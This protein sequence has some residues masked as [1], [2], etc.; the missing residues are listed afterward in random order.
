MWRSTPQFPLSGVSSSPGSS[1]ALS[2]H[3]LWGLC[4]GL[5]PTWSSC[6]LPLCP[7]SPAPS[8]S[9]GG[10]AASW[11]PVMP[12]LPVL[13]WPLHHFCLFLVDSGQAVPSLVS[14]VAGAWHMD[15]HVC[16]GREWSSPHTRCHWIPT[17]HR[18]SFNLLHFLVWFCG[19]VCS[20]FHWEIGV[21]ES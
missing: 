19:S 11:W 13:P 6:L 16:L 21:T 18:V 20:L 10:P 5:S 4:R 2:I 17:R 9:A 8:P 12:V 15:V 1:P 7:L 3:V 14:L